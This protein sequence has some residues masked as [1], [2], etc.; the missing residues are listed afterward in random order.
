MGFGY[1]WADMD[2]NPS[3][4]IMHLGRNTFD[5]DKVVPRSCN[6]LLDMFVYVYVLYLEPAIFGRQ[7]ILTQHQA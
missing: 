2:T 3:R 1:S 5:I 4:T 7:F 6:K